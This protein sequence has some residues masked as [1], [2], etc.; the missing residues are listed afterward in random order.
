M[1]SSDF[2]KL[3]ESLSSV[4][5]DARLAFILNKFKEK[6]LLTT[7]FGTTSALMLHFVSRVKPGFPIHFID[8]GYLFPETLEYKEE[9]TRLLDLN[10]VTIRPD[11]KLHQRT[12]EINMWES[13]PDLCC[14][15][16]KVAPL[17]SI[18]GDFKVW[19]SGLIGYQNSYRT[20][21]DILQNRKDI[22]RFYPLIDWTEDKVNDYFEYF[23]L[24]RHPLERFGFSS[25]GCYHCTKQGENREGRWNGSGKTEC[26]LHT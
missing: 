16:N 25:I 15:Y 20:G 10:V 24:P 23:G 1:S 5:I 3:N 22:F 6:A 21:L 19:I 26:G 4:I 13:N 8:T 11:E 18:K 12:K 9:L 7:S 14:A 17:D 2:S